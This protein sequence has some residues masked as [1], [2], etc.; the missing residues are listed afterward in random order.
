[1]YPSDVQE[2]HWKLKIEL[3]TGAQHLAPCCCKHL[4]V[5]KQR[6]HI[7]IIHSVTV[8]TAAGIG[9]VTE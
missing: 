6:I 1:M 2:E 4:V 5:H 7:E 9:S 3:R 8:I